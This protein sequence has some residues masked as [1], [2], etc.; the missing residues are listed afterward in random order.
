MIDEIKVEDLEQFADLRFD[1][2]DNFDPTI[3]GGDDEEPASSGGKL[4]QE[5]RNMAVI[6][7]QLMNLIKKSNL[8]MSE[9]DGSTKELMGRAEL[10]AETFK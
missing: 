8:D 4:C 3:L 5:C 9:D 7:G 2:L 10:A 6:I 1:M